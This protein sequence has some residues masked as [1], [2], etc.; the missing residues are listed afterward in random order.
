MFHLCRFTTVWGMADAKPV[1]S[2]ARWRARVSAVMTALLIAPLGAQIA[3]GNS[4]TLQAAIDRAL[5]ANPT[6]AA[7]RLASAINLA[8]LALARERPNPEATVEFEKETPKQAFGVALPIE[9]GGKRTKRIAVSEA[10]IRAGEAELAAT[11]VQV[12]NDVRRAYY[13]VLVTDARAS[14]LRE[15]RDLSQRVR[16]TAQARFE[17]GDAPRLEVL[18]A[19][20][21]L[22]GAEN[23]TIA[24]QGV[25]VA[26]RTRLNALLGQPLDMA[27]PLSTPL[28]EGGPIATDA[29][30][31]LARTGSTELAVLDRQIEQQ[32]ARVTL[33]HALRVPDLVPTATLTHDAQPEFT[34]GWRAGLAVTLPILTTH[35]AG[36]LVEQSTLDHLM[37]QRN[38]AVVR[39]TAEVTAAATAAEAQRQTYLRYQ[40]VILPQAQQVEQL[41]QDSYKLGQ[42]GIAALLQALQASRDVRLRSLDAVSAF[43]DAVADLERAIGAPLP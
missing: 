9:L 7:A 20:L 2:G 30:V 13:D 42:T 40:E 27:Q 15:L 1:R 29:T 14:V 6:I 5:A 43:Q 38:A 25:S 41:A 4:L 11:I 33:A 19:T 12:R 32:R 22:A 21:A 39:I 31:D 37:A 18:Q 35:K 34:Y 17:M 36:V 28:A 10:T 26:A 3:P 8:G 24:A 16:D 23:E